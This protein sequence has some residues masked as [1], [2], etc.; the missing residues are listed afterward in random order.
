MRVLIAEDNRELQRI[1]TDLFTMMNFKVQTASD[2]R[3]ALQCLE[4]ELP[5]LVLLDVNLPRV[6]GL[7]VLRYIREE[8]HTHHIRTVLLTG[9]IQTVVQPEAKLA[10]ALLIKPVD[11][12]ELMQT[13][14][15]VMKPHVAVSA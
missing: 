1:L 10:H 8:A 7:E 2:G 15:R 11:I 3:Q 5:D 4:G 9:N 12:H 6:S 14:H 13:V